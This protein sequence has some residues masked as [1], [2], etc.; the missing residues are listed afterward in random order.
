M[1]CLSASSWQWTLIDTTCGF[2]M[3][4]NVQTSA[5]GSSKFTQ[6]SLGCAQADK[7]SSAACAG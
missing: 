4:D 2:F 3:F 6:V 7:Q 1:M 5:A